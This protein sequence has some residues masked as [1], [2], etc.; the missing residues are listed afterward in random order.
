MPLQRR[1]KSIYYVGLKIENARCF[2]EAQELRLVDSNRRPARWSLLVGENGVGKTTLLQCLA[3]MRPI[4]YF[5]PGED[6]QSGIQPWLYDQ[7]PYLMATLL[8]DRVG[9]TA[10]R[11][12]MVEAPDLASCRP[13]TV[14]VR[15]GIQLDAEYS[16]YGDWEFAGAQRIENESATTVEPFVITYA[17]NRYMGRRNADMLS[18]TEPVDLLQTDRTEL[19]DAA[20]FL[21][22]LD[23]STL[24]P[25]LTA[26]LLSCFRTN[27]LRRQECSSGTT[28]AR[29][30]GKSV[31]WSSCGRLP[32]AGRRRARRRWPAVRVRLAWRCARAGCV[33]RGVERWR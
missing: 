10:L 18:D 33:R 17:A 2:T 30:P 16:E 1:Q 14:C 5:P 23:Y 32:A 7:D 24:N 13:S 22:K 31:R 25:S 6:K 21:S 8:R 4:P 9:R 12:E 29:K 11:A 27:S 3:W 26:V 15:T 20:H 19:I 28:N